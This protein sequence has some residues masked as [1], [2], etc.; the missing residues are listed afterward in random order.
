[1]E[2][3]MEGHG[4][5]LDAFSADKAFG[6]ALEP[7]PN[8]LADADAGWPEHRGAEVAARANRDLRLAANG[9]RIGIAARTS[10]HVAVFSLRDMRFE[11]VFRLRAS[12]DMLFSSC[13][14]RSDRR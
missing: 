9:N 12:S 6:P 10:G 7:G 14:S 13:D 5:P 11:F 3:L 8:E 2:N 4:T 1:M